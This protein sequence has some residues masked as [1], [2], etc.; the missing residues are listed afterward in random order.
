M[1]NESI[2]YE[3]NDIQ[4]SNIE[5]L[6]LEKNNEQY[7][8]NIKYS[9]NNFLVSSPI[10]YFRKQIDDNLLFEFSIE[11]NDFYSFI[12]KFEETIHLKLLESKIINFSKQSLHEMFRSSI[13]IPIS[14]NMAPF[15]KTKKTNKTIICNDEN[16][17]LGLEYLKDGKKCK[18]ILNLKKLIFKK[19][20][21]ELKYEIEIL[22]IYEKTEIDDMIL[23]NTDMENNSSEN[24]ESFEAESND[25][26][27]EDNYNKADYLTSTDSCS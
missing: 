19:T 15:L 21:W 16:N 22:K 12:K 23:L 7:E 3:I 8:I 18:L 10:M 11:N 9:S 14:V 5:L 20:F 4:F 25:F 17:I 13:K 1:S 6:D 24:K 2:V 26:N 27:S